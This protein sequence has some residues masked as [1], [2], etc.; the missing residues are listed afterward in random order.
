[1]RTKKQILNILKELKQF[2][3]KSYKV[4]KMW[5]F[6]SVVR[7]EHTP[8]SDID[9]LVDF[10]DNADL[11]TLVGLGMFLEDKL[12]QKVDIGTKRALRKEIKHSVL[13]EVVAV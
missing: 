1:M 11:F 6:G 12:K 4:K 3:K 2:L 7:E 8:K 5:L 9:L 10:Q 13:K